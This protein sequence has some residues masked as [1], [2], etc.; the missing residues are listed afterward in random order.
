MRHFCTLAALSLLLCFSVSSRAAEPS[1][2]LPKEIA[3]E[4]AVKKNQANSGT[5]KFCCKT[6][7]GTACYVFGKSSCSNCSDFCSGSMVIEPV[8]PQR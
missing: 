5:K 8:T 7:G 1:A 3:V 2:G 4:G 6:E